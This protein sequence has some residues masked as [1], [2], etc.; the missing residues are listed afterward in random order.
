M[1]VWWRTCSKR[2]LNKWVGSRRYQDGILYNSESWEILMKMLGNL[3]PGDLIYNNW[4]GTWTTIKDIKPRWIP[5]EKVRYRFGR[6]DWIVD[7]D[8]NYSV[9]EERKTTN[10]PKH[11]KF[12]DE[13]VIHVTEGHAI[14]DFEHLHDWYADKLTPDHNWILF[15]RAAGLPDDCVKF[16]TKLSEV[17]GRRM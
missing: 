17:S 14:Y 6:P 1:K 13:F 3:R 12:I 2:V 15:N 16:P 8:P 4:N 9:D 11:H 5:V 10:G 7:N